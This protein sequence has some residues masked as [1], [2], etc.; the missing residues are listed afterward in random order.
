MGHHPQA[1]PCCSASQ[2]KVRRLEATIAKYKAKMDEAT[3][4]L[5]QQNREIHDLRDTLKG[6]MRVSDQKH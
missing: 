4:L 2:E 5:I 3:S 1:C 6:R